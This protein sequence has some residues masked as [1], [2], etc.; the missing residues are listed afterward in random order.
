MLK[1]AVV[2]RHTNKGR[3]SFLKMGN[4]HEGALRPLL[5]WVGGKRQLL[6][7]LLPYVPPSPS[8]Y[9]EPFVGGGAL[10][11]A[12]QPSHARIND[13]NAELMNVYEV[14]RD[15]PEGLITALRIHQGKHSEDYFYYVRGWD[16][17]SNYQRLSA[18]TRAARTIYLNK[19][20]YNGLYR[21]NK[22]GFFNAPF[23]RYTNPRIVDEPLIRA[24][25]AYF[26]TANITMTCGDYRKAL[27]NI[28]AGG[29]V[30]FDPPYMPVSASSSFTSYTEDGFTWQDQCDLKDECD[31]LT[32]QGILWMM[33]NSDTPQ[34]R[35][36]Y[37]EY[38]L[39]TVQAA[40][41][42]NSKSSQRGLV[43]ELVISNR[44]RM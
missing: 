37:G 36:L 11:F 30:Y 34:L 41:A 39:T 1:E 22:K 12:L 31:R 14:I 23:G 7:D 4:G 24:L 33:S 5:K 42:I 18:L 2:R 38:E 17:E 6:P 16:R 9:V 27:R 25:S 21:V 35:E 40:R 8:L 32:R 29:F 13:A 19:T 26:T 20:C 3:G 43:N 28:P 10:L 44:G 15:N